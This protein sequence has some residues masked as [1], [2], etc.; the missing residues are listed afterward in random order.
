MIKSFL[1]LTLVTVILCLG[2]NASAAMFF[3]NNEQ[4]QAMVSAG[5]AKTYTPQTNA[6]FTGGTGWTRKTVGKGGACLS[7]AYVLEDRAPTRTKTVF[8]Q[9]GF[10]YW[11]HTSGAFRMHKCSNPF[12]SLHVVNQK[13]AQ[14]QQVG[15]CTGNACDDTTR[16]VTRTITV[17]EQVVVVQRCIVN[18]KEVSLVDGKCVAPT[19]AVEAPVV[20]NNPVSSSGGCGATSTCTQKEKVVM[21]REEPRTDGRCFIATNMGYK[22]ELRASKKDGRLMVSM[23]NPSSNLQIEGVRAMYVAQE[24]ASKNEKGIDCDGMQSQLYKNWEPVRS[25]Y[26]LPSICQP[27]LQ[28]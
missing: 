26:G 22:F 3:Q 7:E 23:V 17:I 18:G 11:E 8:V 28:Q 20:V 21:Q 1:Q 19:V 15:P 16:T 14:A 6:P 4:C 24:Q 27:Q 2:A 12:R 13:P 5:K 25:A 9:E 10:E